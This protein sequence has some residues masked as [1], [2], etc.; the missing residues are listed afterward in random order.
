MYGFRLIG[1]LNREALEK[2]LTEIVRRHEALRTTFQLIDGK[3]AQR[4]TEQWSF[5]LSVLDLTREDMGDLDATV[6]RLFENEHRRLFDLSSDL[7]LRAVLL[8]LN[9]DQYVLLLSS[10][11]IA[12]DHWSTKLFLGEMS[13][14]YHA[15]AE[16]SHSPLCDLPI[17]IQALCALAAKN[18]SG[19]GV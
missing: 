7:L 16:G 2:T 19:C 9:T 10:H 3:P 15:F 18:I 13:V 14:L 4:V 6:Q 5:E 11:H 17:P 8:R 12:W 1:L